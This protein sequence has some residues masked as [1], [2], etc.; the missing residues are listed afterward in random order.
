M[1]SFNLNHTVLDVGTTF[2]FGSW[3]CI[4]NGL[5]GSNTH[6]ANPMEPKAS[7]PA[8]C[9]NL[10]E[11]VEN[12]D[13]ILLLELTKEIEKMSI[14][15]TTSIRSPTSPV[16]LDLT[17]SKTPGTQLPLGLRNAAASYLATMLPTSH[18]GS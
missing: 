14:S 4:A 3:V 6:Q 11:I 10:D 2:V 16:G 17:Y 7:S 15:D 12:S 1:A 13:E 8:S 9:S 18:L 5:G